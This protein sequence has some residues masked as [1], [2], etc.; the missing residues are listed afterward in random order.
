M[1]RHGSAPGPGRAALARA[2]T[3]AESTPSG[4]T[5]RLA[6]GRCPGRRGTR[7][8][9]NRP[10]TASLVEVDEEPLGQ[11]QG[12]EAAE[13]AARSSTGGQVDLREVGR[14]QGEP[15][16]VGLHALEPEALVVL[17]G[18]VVDLE[19]A[20]AGRPEPQGT[21]VVAGP[22]HDHLAVPGSRAAPPGVSKNRVRA[23][24]GPRMAGS[25]TGTIAA[26]SAGLRLRHHRAGS[27]DGAESGPPGGHRLAGPGRYGSRWSRR[28]I[29]I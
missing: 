6:P 2:V 27:T 29:D 8:P 28:D 25:P 15:G 23:R 1:V 13:M 21:V 17:G 10:T 18:R 4:W 20:D 26:H 12:G 5:A 11:H 16:Q 19:E 9:P 14:H 24:G 7:T 22:E 3:Q